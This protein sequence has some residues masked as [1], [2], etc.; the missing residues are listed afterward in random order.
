MAER[1]YFGQNYMLPAVTA[2]WQNEM[3]RTLAAEQLAAENA[4]EQNRLATDWRARAEQAELSRVADVKLADKAQENAIALAKENERIRKQAAKDTQRFAME[5]KAREF[6][7][8][9]DTD[10]KSDD[11]LTREIQTVAKEQ[12]GKWRK[13]RDTVEEKILEAGLRMAQ[14]MDARVEQAVRN[15]PVVVAAVQN[16]KK[17]TPEQA[18]KFQSGA[19]SPAD[20]LK[21]AQKNYWWDSNAR[22]AYLSVIN[23]MGQARQAVGGDK[24]TPDL[25]SALNISVLQKKLAWADDLTKRV[26]DDL[27]L[28]ALSMGED[29]EGGG[30]GTVGGID[31][32]ISQA[33]GGMIG[34]TPAGELLNAPAVSPAQ[35]VVRPSATQPVARTIE[36]P[37]D[38]PAREN[39]TPSEAR[40]LAATGGAGRGFA[41]MVGSA[42][43]QARSAWFN[44]AVNPM[45]PPMVPQMVGAATSIANKVLG[46]GN[47]QR[48]QSTL[49][50]WGLAPAATNQERAVQWYNRNE[51]E[52]LRDYELQNPNWAAA[53]EAGGP[54]LAQYLAARGITSPTVLNSS[55]LRSPGRPPVRIPPVITTP[56][57]PEG[58]AMRGWIPNRNAAPP[59]IQQTPEAAM[60]ASAGRSSPPLPRGTWMRP[61]SAPLP[62][63][64]IPQ[65]TVQQP[66]PPNQWMQQMMYQANPMPQTLPP[67]MQAVPSSPWVPSNVPGNLVEIRP[68][69]FMRIQTPPLPSSVQQYRLPG[70]ALNWMYGAPAQ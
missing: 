26:S 52:L 59:V 51:P 33:K 21:I 16:L 17:I 37:V 39:V 9:T 1:N 27:P 67:T 44:P 22:Q 36:E 50:N 45:V 41:G 62:T 5:K 57:T 7:G 43:D 64:P 60:M 42:A 12:F 29:G 8:I 31:Q 18:D 55:L 46:P 14:V 25:S 30:A 20:L 10:K 19:L 4:M 61:P 35:T 3:K 6:Y 48:L 69:V 54:M 28:S 66:V 56:T 65:V 11:Q 49:Q 34:V 13:E 38:V 2:Q 15:D 68:G 70:D 53:G 47:Q 58:I 32:F 63:Q 40:L 23:A 24:Q